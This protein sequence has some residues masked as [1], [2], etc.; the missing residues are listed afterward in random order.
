MQVSKKSIYECNVYWT[1]FVNELTVSKIHQIFVKIQIFSNHVCK[2]TGLS[3]K[4]V[5]LTVK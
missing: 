1:V 4:I 3:P 2:G 5:L